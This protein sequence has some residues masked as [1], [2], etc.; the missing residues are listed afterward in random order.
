M[1]ID[2][3]MRKLTIFRFQVTPKILARAPLEERVLF[4]TLGHIANE[5]NILRKLVLMS[6]DEIARSGVEIERHAQGAQ[7]LMLI[8]LFALKACAGNEFLK[9]QTKHAFM[10]EY[11]RDPEAA[12]TEP[13]RKLSR[14][15]NGESLLEWV[16]NKLA[17]HYDVEQIRGQAA[18][19][20]ARTFDLHVASEQGNSLYF[21]AE[22][23][24][25]TA[26]SAKA[27][28]TEGREDVMRRLIDDVDNVA[29]LLT[30][31]AQGAL[32]VFGKRYAKS[33]WKPEKLATEEV[34]LTDARDV[35][36]PFFVDFKSQFDEQTE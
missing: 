34:P 32:I 14:Y 22:E 9:K 2:R 5:L 18:G 24:I 27:A 20:A 35:R 4:L 31:C 19:P 29:G 17:A 21:A 13:I 33:A 23:M 36:I 12:V 1:M 7:T 26:L 3:P 25:F 6:N 28:A 30:D 15:F 11:A 10:R 16:R 8:K